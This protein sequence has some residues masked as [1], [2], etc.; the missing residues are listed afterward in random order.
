MALLVS[1]APERDV[2]VSEMDEGSST[3]YVFDRVSTTY[4]QFARQVRA[5][6]A[7][8]R[9]W[10]G[11][12]VAL[13]AGHTPDFIINLFALWQCDA[14]PVLL[15]T[16]LP[17]PTVRELLRASD[18]ALLIASQP[19]LCDDPPTAVISAACLLETGAADELPPPEVGPP[20]QE[21]ALVLHTSGTTHLPKLV[22]ITRANLLMSIDLFQARWA[23]HWRSTD[24]SLGWLP[25][26]HVFGLF[27]EL[28][29]TYSR[30]SRYYFASGS[31][32]YELLRNLQ[33]L[34]GQVT[35][36][37]AVPWMVQ[38]LVDLPEGEQAL[39]QLRQVVV[40]GAPLD[41]ALGERLSAAGVRLVQAYG[42]TEIGSGLMGS[43]DGSE[44]RELSPVLPERYWHL[45]QETKQLVVHADCPTLAIHPRQDFVTGDIFE[46]VAPGR[47]RYV[48]RIDDIIVHST[49]EKSN[50]LA[51]EHL[52]LARLGE[53]V[54]RA[55]VVGRGR[56]RLACI[57]VFKREPRAEDQETIR[58]ALVSANAELPSHSQLHP[59]L[60]V[61]LK[62][63]EAARLPMT[64][65]RTVA[66]LR[67]ERELEVELEHLYSGSSGAAVGRAV[68][69]FFEHP[70]QL[71]R[72]Q[73]L[74]EQGLDSL[75]A[76]ALQHHLASLHPEQRIVLNLLYQY[77]TIDK[78]EKYFLGVPDSPRIP[79]AFHE[80]RDEER[81]RARWS[82]APP[83]RVLL[84][85]A[86]GFIGRQLYEELVRAPSVERIY[87]PLRRGGAD[88][89]L[90]DKLIPFVGYDFMDPHFGLSPSSYE[91][92][93]TDVDTIVH[94]AWPVNFNLTYEQLAQGTLSAM[95]NLV[96]FASQGDKAI[97]FV[98]SV[99][100]VMLHPTKKRVDEEW[101]L[102]TPRA[103]LP[104]GYAQ[105]KWEAEHLLIGS[106]VRHKI[107][108]L[109]QISAHSVTGKWNSR[110]HIPV[111]LRAA[112]IV[113]STPRFPQPID[114]VP[115]DIACKAIVELMTV[116]D[117]NVHHIANPHL[118]AADCLARRT[119]C[120][121]LEEWLARTEKLDTLPDLMALWG[122]LNDLSRWSNRL[123]SLSADATC[124]FSPSLASCPEI[125]DDYLDN[126]SL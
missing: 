62:P 25:L 109:A 70:Q 102:P 97:H 34:D 15:S 10:G 69:S 41:E 29:Q 89:P 66:R 7:E 100:T 13:W 46:R 35:R 112:R 47:Y 58:A 57:L 99:S 20:A 11:R 27:A 61:V 54:E 6:A 44:W 78:L 51:I 23:D 85:G 31:N 95:R 60:V 88:L 63:T 80:F 33:R 5:R 68:T 92:L 91:E 42:M 45:D 110:D 52:L 16:R 72:Y 39:R 24:G 116:P 30:G 76:V 64:A 107:F 114:W 65:K 111:V 17:W 67:A 90:S 40:G 126:L 106:G 49:G 74:F 28:L 113:G 104:I 120:I 121:P 43:L 8:L 101:P 82:Y 124:A 125:T 108:R 55:A 103:C 18:A 122:F 75:K 21:I 48:N 53:L 56:L 36:L 22:R 84:T 96:A 117:H 98:S 86:N 3:F 4:A 79:P 14:T 119:E 37:F 123:T 19:D 105:T 2:G 12:P 73:S 118:R 38:Q 94:A 50:A 71:N 26:F 115:V 93:A 87:C 32:H 59:E 1:M 81:E 83:R 77:P 9:R